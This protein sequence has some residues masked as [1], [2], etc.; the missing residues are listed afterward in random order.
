MYKRRTTHQRSIIQ[1][2]NFWKERQ[3]PYNNNLCLFRPLTLP[4]H[5]NGELEKETSKLLAAYLQNME[6]VEAA[7]FL[8]V[9]MS[10]IPMVDYL[11]K[12]NNLLFDI[13]IVDGTLVEKRTIRREKYANTVRL[14][15]WNSHICF[16][17]NIKALFKIY[18]CP[19]C[20]Q[21]SNK[22][23]NRGRQLT[24]GKERV[25][26]FFQRTCISSV[27]HFLTN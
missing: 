15:R 4:L 6:D 10:V 24:T 14:L 25:T 12:T 20:D 5:D 21:F 8:G 27:K 17:W 23:G 2:L 18:R 9:C 19:S 22:A 26:H 13:D 7:K 11:T 1:L 16:L 3:K